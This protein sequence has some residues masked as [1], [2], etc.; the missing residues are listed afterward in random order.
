[1]PAAAENTDLPLGDLE[2]LLMEISDN[3]RATESFQEFSASVPQLQ[4]QLQLLPWAEELLHIAKN[5]VPSLP[6]LQLQ[7]L[8]QVLLLRRRG[9]FKP[10]SMLGVY[11]EMNG[12]IEIP[13]HLNA[14]GV[15]LHFQLAA[16]SS[17]PFSYVV[18][19]Q[20]PIMMA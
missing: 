17:S 5:Q 7:E 6:L 13:Y 18:A 14:V 11:R 8:L 16:S 9:S 20:I 3:Q 4:L 12:P 1:M 10:I 19:R 15:N 2:G